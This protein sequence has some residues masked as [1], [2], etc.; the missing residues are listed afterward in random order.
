MTSHA[1]KYVQL[2]TKVRNE[3]D[4]DTDV[5][6]GL[7]LVEAELLSA[8]RALVRAYGH[9]RDALELAEARGSESARRYLDATTWDLT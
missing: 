8:E 3:F 4:A 1:M 9:W 5:A 6:R 7:G 2:A